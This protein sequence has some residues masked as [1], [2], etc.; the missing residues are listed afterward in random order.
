MTSLRFERLAGTAGIGFV[1]I[2]VVANLVLTSAGYPTPSDSPDV[3]E[4]TAV[5]ATEQAAL[6]FASALLPG[7]WVLA[8]VFA[9]GVFAV[10]W[11]RDRARSGAWALVGLAGIL[12]QCAVFAGVE[13]SRSALASAAV[14]APATVPGLWGLHNALFGVNQVF[15]AT[16]LLGVSIGARRAGVIGGW[17]AGTGL[18]A[19]TLLFASAT[20]S[21]YGGDG[22]NPLALLG[23]V[24]W[25]LWLVWIV[26]LGLALLRG[27]ASRVPGPQPAP[28]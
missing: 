9:V 10:L 24:G 13:A 8:T 28:A 21:P 1:L 20:T 4:V 27:V 14:H 25:L 26:V 5:F 3:A 16:A 6:R 22:A 18:L 11:R 2:L 15:L 12:L 7:A 17:A 19:A 23:L